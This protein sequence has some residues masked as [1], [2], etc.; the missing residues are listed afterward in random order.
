L[1]ERFDDPR[2]ARREKTSGVVAVCAHAA[3]LPPRGVS[4]AP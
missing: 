4:R 2:G 3:I 1:P